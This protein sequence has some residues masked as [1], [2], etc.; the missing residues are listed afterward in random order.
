M[1]DRVSGNLQVR[2]KSVS[3]VDGV[4]V[5]VPTCWLFNS[6]GSRFRKGTMAS[7]HLSVRENPVLQL[8]QL[9]A[10]ILDP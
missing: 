5:M 7:A 9:A 2:A 4:S 8:L 6:V 10:V 3:L 1:E